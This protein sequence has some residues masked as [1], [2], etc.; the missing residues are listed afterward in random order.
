MGLIKAR[1][2]LSSIVKRLK[3]R[4][5]KIVFANGCFDILHVGHIRYLKGAKKKGDVLIVGINSDKSVRRIKGRGR[6]IL[7][8]GDRAKLVSAIEVVDYVT[9]FN[10]DNVERT[11]EVLRPDIHVKGTDYT[12]D[13]VPEKETAK[14]LGIKIVIAG[15]KKRHSTKELLKTIIGKYRNE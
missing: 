9:I 12:K 10:E 4:G 15:D 14:R 8:Q 5:K 11:L 1:K 7:S 6:P 13:T 3:K 2:E